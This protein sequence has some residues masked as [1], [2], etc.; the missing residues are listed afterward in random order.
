V[1][2][3]LVEA[4]KEFARSE[5]DFDLVGVTSAAPLAGRERLLR[6][7]ETGYAGDMAF[8][9]RRPEQRATPTAFLAKART[10]VC[11]AMSYHDPL[12]PPEL[13]I[14]DGR[15]VVARYARRRDYHKV[16]KARL[17]RLGRFVA[18]QVP[19]L[20][21]RVGVDGIPLLEREL[22]QRAG[23][24]WIGKN[25]CL[26]NRTL[27]SE[28]LLGEL[29]TDFPLPLDGPA[30]A[31]NCGSCRRCLEACPTGALVAPGV[32]DARLCISY[33][34]IEHRKALPAERRRLVGSHLFG[35]DICQAVCPWNR[36]APARVAAPLRLR[37]AL[38]S[39][40]LEG[41]MALGEQEWFELAKGS[42]LRR[43][44]Y[45]RFRRNLDAVAHNVEKP[46]ALPDISR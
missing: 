14:G 38:A 21:W 35:C 29:L 17:V 39:L 12:E 24:G 20:H 18:G 1:E 28:L 30:R 16:V 3:T 34:T 43:L 41:L 46:G 44:S 10:V 11:V 33:L 15:V 26:L 25:T 31:G 7:A 22:A 42:P 13:A 9:R 40:A 45:A 32:L 27:G 5:L 4:I 8:M 6:W 23:L 37:P 2:H 36:H 19:G